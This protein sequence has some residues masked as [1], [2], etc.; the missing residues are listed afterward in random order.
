MFEKLFL[1]V[2]CLIS[3]VYSRPFLYLY[4]NSNM[5]RR[6]WWNCYAKWIHE[7]WGEENRDEEIFPIV[8][9]INPKSVLE[10]GCGSGAV[11]KSLLKNTSVVD[12]YAQEISPK[13]IEMLKKETNINPKN[14]FHCDIINVTRKI[15]LIISNRVMSAVP[16]SGIASVIKHMCS[17]SDYIYLNELTFDR[18][19]KESFYLYAH[20]YDVLMGKN[21]FEEY[22]Y[23][24]GWKIYKKKL[25]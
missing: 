11:I 3:R 22:K 5:F 25:R 7:L 4:N 10:V 18:D 19:F 8:E 14:V 16:P 23:G 12:V 15:D 20:N 17:I 21:N 2:I 9:Y 13:A 6:F 1:R 24:Q